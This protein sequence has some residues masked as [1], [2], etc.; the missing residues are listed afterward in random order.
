MLVRSCHCA[1]TAK[2]ER[3]FCRKKFWSAEVDWETDTQRVKVKLSNRVLSRSLPCGRLDKPLSVGV[4]PC[5]C[6]HLPSAWGTTS[7]VRRL[8][9]GPPLSGPAMSVTS[10]NLYSCFCLFD[11]ISCSFNGKGADQLATDGRQASKLQTLPSTRLTREVGQKNNVNNTYVRWRSIMST[12]CDGC[13]HSER[14]VLNVATS[15][16]TVAIAASSMQLH[17]FTLFSS[18]WILCYNR[19]C[20]KTTF[21][22]VEEV[23]LRCSSE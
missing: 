1:N 21:F 19:L 3:L 9:F 7:D 13:M 10:R 18:R 16:M 2:V 11:Y 12:S 17:N 8:R 22:T 15:L 20:Q 14:A 6:F 4:S 5:Q 23:G